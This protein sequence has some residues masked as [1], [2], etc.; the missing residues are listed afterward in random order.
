MGS[1]DIYAFEVNK[2]T[3]KVEIQKAFNSMY[4]VKPLSVRIINMPSKTKRF[5]KNIGTQ[6]AWKK[7][8]VRI[9]KGSNVSIY[10]GV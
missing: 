10:E 7:A 1:H 2:S 5:G 3:N 9:P 4:G 8:Y 6:S